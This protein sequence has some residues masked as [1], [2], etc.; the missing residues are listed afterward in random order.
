MTSTTPTFSFI[1]SSATLFFS[2]YA[3][4]FTHYYTLYYEKNNIF[5]NI[6]LDEVSKEIMKSVG[7]TTEPLH[8]QLI[9][10]EM[11]LNN[12]IYADIKKRIPELKKLFSSSAMTSLQESA[13]AN[14]KWPLLNLVRQILHGYKYEMKPIRK[15]DGYTPEGV[16]KYKRFFQIVMSQSVLN[17]IDSDVHYVEMTL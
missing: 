3:R 11:L 17:A 14:Q 2:S 6:M 4:R 8:G 16:K 13:E 9:P 10:R 7:I 5:R 12:S 1:S 15:S